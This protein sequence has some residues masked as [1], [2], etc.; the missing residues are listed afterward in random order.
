MGAIT[1][2][3]RHYSPDFIIKHSRCLVLHE[4]IQYGRINAVSKKTNVFD[5]MRGM[6]VRTQSDSLFVVDKD[7]S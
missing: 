4:K 7:A 5:E 3:T 1:L 6:V 2:Y